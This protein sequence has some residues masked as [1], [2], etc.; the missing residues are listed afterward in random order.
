MSAHGA[1]SGQ[2]GS[3]ARWFARSPTWWD[4]HYVV[5]AQTIVNFLAGDGVAIDGADLLDLGC[6]DGIISAGLAV[7]GPLSVLGID[8]EPV[9]LAFL[10]SQALEHGMPELPPSLR[11]GVSTPQSLGVA[12][13]SID[14]VTA[15]SV[16][17]HVADPRDLLEQVHAVLRPGGALFIQVW[18]LWF[19]QH[20]AHMWPWTDRGFEHLVRAPSDFAAD[21]DSAIKDPLLAA[22]FSDLVQSCNRITVDDLQLALLDAGF[23]IAKVAL[24]ADTFHVRA[25]LQRVPL[26]RLGI[27]GVQLLAVRP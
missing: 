23:Y 21:L 17:E 5:A 22:S 1:F 24:Q 8:L 25:E 7:L 9:D 12:D 14:I 26:S 15:W 20:G 10:R 2:S 19:S 4:D 11:F 3:A 27:S 6:G 13:G 16:F 18:P